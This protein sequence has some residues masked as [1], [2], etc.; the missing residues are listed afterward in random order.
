[1]LRDEVIENLPEEIKNM[2]KFYC[3]NDLKHTYADNEE[4]LAEDVSRGW[5]DGFVTALEGHVKCDWGWTP[6]SEKLPDKTDYYEVT[7]EL[8]TI[9]PMSCVKILEYD[10]IGHR[11][12]TD[13][14][15]STVTAWKPLTPPYHK[16]EGDWVVRDKEPL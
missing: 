4:Q 5:L 8:D 9:T 11:W 3:E 13:D 7:L 6:V 2:A 10:H 12:V 14:Q 16:P 1:M 15:R